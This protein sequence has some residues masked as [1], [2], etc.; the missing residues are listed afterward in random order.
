MGADDRDDDGCQCRPLG[1]LIG[2]PFAALALVL[3]LAGA[4]V[5]ILGFVRVS[6]WLL[7]GACQSELWGACDFGLDFRFSASAWL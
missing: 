3:S 2:L 5:W 1:L 6:F 7:S 4:V